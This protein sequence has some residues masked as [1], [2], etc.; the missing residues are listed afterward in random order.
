MKLLIDIGN[1]LAKVVFAQNNKLSDTQVFGYG[2]FELWLQN[3]NEQ[4]DE[5]IFANVG[6]DKL[7]HLIKSWALTHNVTFTQARTQASLY[8]V[9]CGYQQEQQLGID[10]WLAVLGGEYL[11]PEKNLLIVDSGTAT[12]V[13][14]LDS[15]GMHHGG[16]IIPGHQMMHQSVLN[17]TSKVFAEIIEN[18]DTGFGDN[19]SDNLNNGC[20]AATVGSVIY[21]YQLA[22]AQVSEV[23]LIVTGGQGNNLSS[24]LPQPSIVEPQLIFYGLLRYSHNE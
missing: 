9:Q 19:T 18:A 3:L 22:K 23:E 15:T 14:F 24:L 17:S 6:Q 5:V 21:G 16:W 10:R 20:W 11:Y 1:T 8:K 2:E 7:S 4:L 13:D 12:T